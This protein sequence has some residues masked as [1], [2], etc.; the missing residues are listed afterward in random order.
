MWN[1]LTKIGYSTGKIGPQ[2][3]TRSRANRTFSAA[4]TAAAA[5]TDGQDNGEQSRNKKEGNAEITHVKISLTLDF[6]Y[7]MLIPG[8]VR[9]S[10]PSL[11]ATR[12]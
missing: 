8:I 10:K 2:S 7:W 4:T 9:N 11:V 5:T 1:R 3:V 12:V 6:F